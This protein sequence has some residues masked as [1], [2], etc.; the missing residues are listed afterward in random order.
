[1]I[2]FLK[3][4]TILGGTFTSSD[5]DDRKDSSKFDRS[6]VAQQTQRINIVYQMSKHDNSRNSIIASWVSSDTPN[7]IKTIRLNK[8]HI[9][10]ISQVLNSCSDWILSQKCNKT[11]R[12]QTSEFKPSGKRIRELSG[13]STYF[14][15]LNTEY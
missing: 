14:R 15:I 8:A 5:V 7:D 12:K 6:V 11:K 13:A 2:Q 1:M 10:E 4:F 3:S 9:K